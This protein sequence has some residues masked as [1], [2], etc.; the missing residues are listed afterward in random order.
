MQ[1]LTH[2]LP[3]CRWKPCENVYATK[4]REQVIIAVIRCVKTQPSDDEA[5]ED[6]VI[7]YS[8]DHKSHSCEL[9]ICSTKNIQYATECAALYCELKISM[10]IR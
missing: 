8:V 10:L 2:R 1:S 6:D 9:A 3:T 5:T 7:I 4:Q